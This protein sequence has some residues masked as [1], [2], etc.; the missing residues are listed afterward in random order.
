METTDAGGSARKPNGSLGLA[1]RVRSVLRALFGPG[2]G[3]APAAY[4]DSAR[5]RDDVLARYP[6]TDAARALART[7]RFEVKNL[8]A[9]VGGGGWYGPQAR[10]IVLEGVQDEAALHELAHAWADL[11]GFY[12][13]PEPGGP[14]WPTRHR[15]FREAVRA[16][17]E[18]ADPRFERVR[19]LARQY[20]YGDAAIGFPGMGENDAERFAGLASGTMGDLR[21]MPPYLAAFYAGLFAPARATET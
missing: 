1:R 12:A 7:V 3:A 11:T 13:E 21:L 2:L 5:F 14:P 16:A 4:A 15:A 6:F 18:E 20:E 19:F 10:R 17:A 9:P 8:H